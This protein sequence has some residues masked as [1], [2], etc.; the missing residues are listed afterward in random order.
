MGLSG[1]DSVQAGINKHVTV[2][3]GGSGVTF[4]MFRSVLLKT[5]EAVTKKTDL[6]PWYSILSLS[7]VEMERKPLTEVN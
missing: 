4:S 1:Q 2:I 6:Y 7:I 3:Q 5:N